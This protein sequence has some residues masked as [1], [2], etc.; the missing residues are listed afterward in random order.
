MAYPIIPTVSPEIMISLFLRAP[1]TTGTNGGEQVRAVETMITLSASILKASFSDHFQSDA[2]N[3]H[4]NK[5]IK[6]QKIQFHSNSGVCI[7]INTKT[8]APYGNE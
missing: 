4:I 1:A 3:K 8:T 7:Y 6:Y 5:Y 2:G